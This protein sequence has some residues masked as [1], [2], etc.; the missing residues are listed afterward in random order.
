MSRTQVS[1]TTPDGACPASLFTP[2]GKGPGPWPAAVMLMDA[3]AIRPVMFEN[4]Q[5]LADSGYAVLLPDL[6]YRD[7][8]YEPVTDISKLFGDEEVRKALFAKMGKATNPDAARSDMKAF[9]DFLAGRPEVKGQAVGV[10]GYCMGGGLA[11]RAAAEFPERVAAAGAFHPGHIA[12][13]APDSPHLGAP[14]MKAKVFVGG[15]D[16][17]QGFPPEQAERLSQ[18]FAEAGVDARVEIFEGAKHGYV[19]RDLAVYD[20]GAAE[21]HWRELVSLFDSALKQAA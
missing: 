19:M 10:T 17:D 4:A 3:V 14:R 16:E 12:T 11:L 1:I 5:R 6:F 8:P 2:D 21:R 7:G 13:D 18:A 9:L 20:E 15:A